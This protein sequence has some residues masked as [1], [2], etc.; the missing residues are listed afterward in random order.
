MR[1]DQQYTKTFLVRWGVVL[2]TVTLYTV[3]LYLPAHFEGPFLDGPG[4]LYS[5]L[6]CLFVPF[7]EPLSIII[8]PY[9]WANPLF[10]IGLLCFIFK[11]DHATITLVFIAIA[12]ASAYLLAHGL[13]GCQHYPAFYFWFA[14]LSAL[15]LGALGLFIHSLSNL[16]TDE[17][18]RTCA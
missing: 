4:K 6:D 2:L 3:A 15:W 8:C 16:Q 17:P 10:A 1:I 18:A 11:V 13:P 14:S 12:H 9:W 7:T 5:G